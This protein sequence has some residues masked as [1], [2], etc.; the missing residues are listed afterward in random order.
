MQALAATTTLR[1]LAVVWH[2]WL[3]IRLDSWVYLETAT[4]RHALAMIGGCGPSTWRSW[5]AG[6]SRGVGATARAAGG[7]RAGGSVGRD[8]GAG[9]DD[10]TPAATGRRRLPS[11]RDTFHQERPPGAAT[12]ACD[13]HATPMPLQPRFPG[14]R[15]RHHARRNIGLAALA[16]Q[17]DRSSK[18]GAL[19]C[20]G[21]TA[22][23][24]IPAVIRVH[25]TNHGPARRNEA[26][27]RRERRCFAELE[28]EFLSNDE[29]LFATY[30][31]TSVRRTR[32][33]RHSGNCRPGPW[34]VAARLTTL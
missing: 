34:T 25:S 30:G 20:D 24:V 22:H 3:L 6:N 32:A 26:C 33:T 4:Q 2:E 16:A 1:L 12:A 19:Q 31:G 11:R 21:A 9:I 8:G 18:D 29:R 27:G 7:A 14:G 5:T 10:W 28:F 13:S 17:R 23:R 15:S